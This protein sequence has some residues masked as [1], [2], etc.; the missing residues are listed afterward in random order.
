MRYRQRVIERLHYR[1]EFD[2]EFTHDEEL[3]HDN[4]EYVDWCEKNGL[5]PYKCLT[6]LYDYINGDYDISHDINTDK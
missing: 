1:S 2:V 5:S 6:F 3:I 4:N